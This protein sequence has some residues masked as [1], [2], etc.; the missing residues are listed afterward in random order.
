MNAKNQFD[1][2]DDQQ[3]R[4]L[5]HKNAADADMSI[6]SVYDSKVAS[7]L[8]PFFSKNNATATRAFARAAGNPQ[9]DIG[10]FPAD[11]TL[12][13]IGTFS[14][15]CGIISET[16]MHETLCNGLVALSQMETN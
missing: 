14:E 13:K 10:A 4:A 11:F 1:A 5:V 9:S 7:F 3:R 6:Y 12:F 8:T 2:T 15:L 16:G